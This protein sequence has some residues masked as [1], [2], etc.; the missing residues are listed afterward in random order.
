MDIQIEHIQ[1]VLEDKL[2]KSTST[3]HREETQ[4]IQYWY[5][6]G[7]HTAYEEILQLIKNTHK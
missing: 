1:Y 7:K 2:T 6:V 4:D 5:H 3:I